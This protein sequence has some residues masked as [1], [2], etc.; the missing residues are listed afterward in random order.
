MCG[1]IIRSLAILN[2]RISRHMLH[3]FVQER[4][5]QRVPIGITT[6]P[7]R[8][9]IPMMR[10]HEV[11]LTIPA[12]L[13]PTT[14]DTVVI[15]QLHHHNQIIETIMNI[16]LARILVITLGL[17]RRGGHLL[18]YLQ[19]IIELTRSR[20]HHLLVRHL[21]AMCSMRCLQLDT[22]ER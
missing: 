5:H 2:S 11:L 6:Q 4:H 15:I 9:R 7:L 13:H 19:V 22:P 20:H 17:T 12:H 8:N 18:R 10:H 14:T 16:I 21:G 1:P 3:P